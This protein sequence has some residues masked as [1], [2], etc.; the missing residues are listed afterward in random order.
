MAD[1]E[2]RL[3]GCH[4]LIVED[5]RV[6][7]AILRQQLISGGYSHIT[8]AENGKKGL[9]LTRELK[10]DLV[11]LDIIMPEMDGFEYC[12]IVQQEPE[13]SNIPIIVQTSLE[14]T[15][16]MVRAFALGASDYI[17]KP[18][19]SLEL[20][21]RIKVHLTSKLLR[22]ETMLQ[23]QQ[24][25]CELVAAQQMQKNL[26]PSPEQM[27][28]AEQLYRMKIARHFET[29]SL[30]GGDLWGMRP[31]SDTRLA[32]Y[33]L[34]FSGHGIS[35]AFNVFRMH[36]LMQELASHG[37][38][39]G[40]FLTRLNHHLYPLI[41][42]SEFA[43]MFY[44]VIDIEANSLEYAAAAA[45][46][47]LLT[48]R[49][50]D[51]TEWLDGRGFPLGATEHANYTTIHTPFASGD[52]LVLFSDCLIETPNISGEMMGKRMIA[53]RVARALMQG[54][55]EASHIRDQLLESFHAHTTLPLRDDLTL[56]V[57][58]RE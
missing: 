15:E 34:D 19:K 41:E 36:T 4:L 39:A 58:C 2:E 51:G 49:I 26:M 29:S 44:A 7:T 9:A 53:E 22:E 52:A 46:P 56:N 48:R 18:I 55:H 20:L 35:A 3:S 12:Q 8:I 40:P 6:N 28:I 11:I 31:I 50:A 32:V 24:M 54:G 30:M 1:L 10:P 13:L 47:A 21:A 17:H 42:R 45:P 23:Q 14:R 25:H 5:G 27:R 16:D 37:N 33:V 57:Y 43:T 38:D